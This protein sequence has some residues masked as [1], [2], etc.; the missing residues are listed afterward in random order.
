MRSL[1]LSLVWLAG[2]YTGTP[3]TRDVSASWRG[4][5]AHDIEERWGAPG[6]R[7][8]TAEG[9]VLRWSHEIIHVQLPEVT[10]VEARPVA[11]TG[12]IDTPIGTAALHV[13]T[14]LLAVA[15]MP[16][17]Q[18]GE[19]WK[20]STDTI[21]VV[22]PAGR[23]TR[24]DGESLRWGPPN[25]ENLKWGV[26][27]GA[28]VGMGRLDTTKTALPSGGLYL[29]GMLSQTLGLVGTFALVTG[30]DD[31]GGAMG[32]G[33]GIAAQWWPVNRFSL[34]AGPAMLLT[35]DPGFTDARLHPGVTTS[36]S[37]A[38]LKV[39]V[40]ALDLRFDLAAARTTTFGSVGVGVN[41]N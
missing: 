41:V 33:W 7:G 32:F 20:T 37:Y 22:D 15:A 19:V 28:H 23:I 5:Q 39:G 25:D 11:A 18:P 9:T 38:L 29:G 21:A 2:C 27:F 26:I 24:V 35:L 10:P 13:E 34:R 6:W 3:A 4:H 36:A 16:A 30:S 31:A 12:T 17:I 8:P 40:F 14:P 1:L